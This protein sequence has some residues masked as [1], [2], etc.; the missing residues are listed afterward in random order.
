MIDEPIDTEGMVVVATYS[1][2]TT[3]TVEDYT[4]Y[5]YDTSKAGTN[6]VRIE[7]SEGGYTKMATYTITVKDAAGTTPDE[8]SDTGSSFIGR[9]G[10]FFANIALVFGKLLEVILGF[11]NS[12]A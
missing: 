11:A 4:V 6:I 8:P 9:I 2:G 7:Y 3:R 10:E 5:D 12:A 1:D